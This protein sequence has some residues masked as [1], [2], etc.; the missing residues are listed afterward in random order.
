MNEKEGARQHP[1]IIRIEAVGKRML[2]TLILSQRPIKLSTTLS[3]LPVSYLTL[4]L[5]LSA[6]ILRPSTPTSCTILFFFGPF[7][8]SDFDL[9]LCQVS[10]TVAHTHTHTSIDLASRSHFDLSFSPFFRLSST[11]RTSCCGSSPFFLPHPCRL[12][13]F[14][15]QRYGYKLYNALVTPR[16]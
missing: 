4:P 12:V 6:S 9:F 5:Y 3:R 13:A 10:A 14:I 2:S 16:Y 15:L 8:I 11:C 7:P 1:T